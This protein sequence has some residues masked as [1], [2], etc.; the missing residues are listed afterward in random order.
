VRFRK[1]SGKQKGKLLKAKKEQKEEP[2]NDR[3]HIGGT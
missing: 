1:E 2:V 3:Q